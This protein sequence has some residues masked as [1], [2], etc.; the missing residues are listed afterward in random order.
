MRGRIIAGL[1][2]LGVVALTGCSDGSSGQPNDSFNSP[3]AHPSVKPKLTRLAGADAKCHT[4]GVVT[5]EGQALVMNGKGTEDA[6]G[7]TVTKEACLL[8]YVKT[9]TYVVDQMD[10]TTSLMG[11]RQADWNGYH[12]EW[13]YHPDNGL[14]IT[15]VD[16]EF[17]SDN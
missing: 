16:T 5:D 17:K 7:L 10:A 4:T 8:L 13:S 14:D 12:A 2:V 1:A 15:I 3:L 6:T 9:P 11:L